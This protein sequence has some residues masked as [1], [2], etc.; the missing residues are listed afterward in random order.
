VTQILRL[1]LG[2]SIE[3]LNAMEEGSV[4]GILCDPPYG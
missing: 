2:D 4:G 3:V 1:R